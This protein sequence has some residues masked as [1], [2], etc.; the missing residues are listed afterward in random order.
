MSWGSLALADRLCGRTVIAALSAA[1]KREEEGFVVAEEPPRTAGAEHS[2]SPG[3]Q[4]E[5]CRRHRCLCV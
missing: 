2:Y 4:N 3:N 1:G 5:A